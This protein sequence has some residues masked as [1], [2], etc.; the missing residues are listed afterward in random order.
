MKKL[1][2]ACLTLMIIL[3]ATA[4][5]QMRTA[6]VDVRKIYNEWK[7]SKEIQAKIEK[8]REEVTAQN[9][10]RMAV[11]NQYRL[12]RNILIQKYQAGEASMTEE[13][14]KKAAAK[15]R[16]LGRNASALEQDRIDFFTKVRRSLGNDISFQSRMI[17]E[18]ISEAIQVYAL[19][20]KYD[21][22]IETGGQT[23]R[24]VPFFMYIEG[25]VDITEEILTRLNS[26]E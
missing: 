3:Q 16:D 20:K 10:D 12:D 7:L 23:T 21:M 25:S 17:L 26:A 9:N 22:V 15:I 18:R 8:K 13:E 1:L 24:H 11:I 6:T 2:G 4:S 14:K 5:A 19:E